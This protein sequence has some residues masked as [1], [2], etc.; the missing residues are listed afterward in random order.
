[1]ALLGTRATME[2]DFYSQRF[3]LNSGAKIITPEEN[4]RIEVNRIIFDE[5]TRGVQSPASREFM[6]ELIS[7]LYD[8]GAEAVVLGCSELTA[9]VSPCRG[10]MRIYD[11]TRLHAKAAVKRA[12]EVTYA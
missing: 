4:E 1:M 12:L 2:A 10:A 6:G 3:Q 5:L 9:I 11:T 7:K 8:R